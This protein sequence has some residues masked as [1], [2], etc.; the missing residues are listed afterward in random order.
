MIESDVHHRWEYRKVTHSHFGYREV[1]RDEKR[2]QIEELNALG[3]DGWEL[4]T[5]IPITAEDV[6]SEIMYVF[7]R[8]ID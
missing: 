6:T 7:K 1:D 8:R 2:R 3:A 4:V 5:A